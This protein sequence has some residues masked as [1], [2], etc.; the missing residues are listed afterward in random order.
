MIIWCQ[1]FRS[2]KTSPKYI[3]FRVAIRRMKLFYICSHIRVLEHLSCTSAAMKRIW[4]W[5]L[6]LTAAFWP[7]L[8]EGI[9]HLDVEKTSPNHNHYGQCLNGNNTFQKGAFLRWAAVG[10]C[11]GWPCLAS[12]FIRFSLFKSNLWLFLPQGVEKIEGNMDP[13]MNNNNCKHNAFLIK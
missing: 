12:P 5:G 6:T 2:L 3:F 4:R 7:P 9:A 13:E 8:K 11:S 1:W 10:L